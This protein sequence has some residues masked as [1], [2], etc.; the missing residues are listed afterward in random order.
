MQDLL[1]LFLSVQHVGLMCLDRFK[2][3]L[4]RLSVSLIYGWRLHIVKLQC[5][6]AEPLGW[7]RLHTD[8]VHLIGICQIMK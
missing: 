4:S 1:I 6:P 5:D 2:F 3:F 7:A 8:R